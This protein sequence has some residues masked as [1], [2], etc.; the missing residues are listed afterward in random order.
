MEKGLVL[1]INSVGTLL[2]CLSGV[3]VHEIGGAALLGIGKV[4]EAIISL[5]SPFMI[6]VN[7]NVFIAY[8]F[9]LGLFEVRNNIHG[10]V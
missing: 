9:V 4:G 2:A 6:N 5:T 7:V 3:I 8:R 10:Y 1:G